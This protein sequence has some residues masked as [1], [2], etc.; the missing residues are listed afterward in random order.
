MTFDEQALLLEWRGGDAAAGQELFRRHYAGLTRFFRSKAGD[1]AFALTQATFQACMQGKDALHSTTSFPAYLYSLAR[2]LLRDHYRGKYRV[3][4]PIEFSEMACEDLLPGLTGVQ[5]KE[6]ELELLLQA[7]R[8]IPLNSQIVLELHHW[9]QLKALEI[10]E[11]L[12]IPE[13]TVRGRLRDAKLQLEAQ[14]TRL[15]RSPELARSTIDGFEGWSEQLR[16]QLAPD[17]TM[18]G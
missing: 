18:G 7:M 13:G 11:V 17:D 16:Q 1:S 4:G 6:P 15:A 3:P 5:A 9:A 12:A 2:N 8:R 10:G 14:L